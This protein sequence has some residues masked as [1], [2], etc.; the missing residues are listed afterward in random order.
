MAVEE[1][2]G[3]LQQLHLADDLLVVHDEA[4]QEVVVDL[5]RPASDA[6]NLVE[7]RQLAHGAVLADLG[8]RVVLRSRHVEARLLLR[9]QI[10]ANRGRRHGRQ[11]R[12]SLHGRLVR[13]GGRAR[14]ATDYRRFR[15][16]ARRARLLAQS[17]RNGGYLRGDASNVAAV[18]AAGA[19][20]NARRVRQKLTEFLST[21]IHRKL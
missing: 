16:L 11:R 19:P 20:G 15:R 12:R 1:R 10:H 18:A 4:A 14:A 9:D 5:A 21:L 13:L 6:P 8:D 3:E 17:S 7:E 2:R